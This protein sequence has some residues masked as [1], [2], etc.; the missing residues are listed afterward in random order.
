MAWPKICEGENVLITAPTGSGKTHT[1]FLWS[2]N[3]FATGD[4]E[5]GRTRVLYISPLKALNNDIQRNLLAPLAELEAAFTKQGESF[6]ELSIATRSGDTSSEE[7]RRMLRKPPDILI[8]TPESLN[9]LLSSRGGQ[10]LLHDVDTVILDEIHG[11][12]D[13]K[14][15][16]YLMSAV[17]RLVRFSGEFQRIALS[18]TINPLETVARFVAGF[19]REKTSYVPRDIKILQS[20]SNKHYDIAI[21]YPEKSLNRPEDEQIWESMAEDLLE[22]IQD[23]QSTLIFVNSRALCEKLTFKINSAARS[24]VAYAHHGSLSREIRTD[25]E[26]RLKA[27]ELAAIV[28]TSSLE[29]GIDIGALDEVILVQSPGSIASTIQRIGRAGH[30]VGATSRCTIYPT[31]PQDF[32][33]SAVLAKSVMARAIEPV[34]TIANPL[35]VLGQVIIS[36]TGTDTWDLDELF[37]E[38]RCSTPYNTLT[39][40]AFDLVINMLLGR[41]AE[42]H[43]HDLKPRIRLDRENNTAEAR[44]GALLSLYLSGGVIPD[45]GYFQLRV[46]GSNARLGELDEEFVWEARV[47]KVFSLGTQSWQVKK[48]THNDVLVAPAK[49]DGIAPPFWKSESISRS[50]EYSSKIGEFLEDAEQRVEDPAFESYLIEQHYTEPA[51]AK[52]IVEFLKQQREQTRRPLPHR[53]HLLFE[54]VKRGPAQ[55]SGSQLVIHSGWGAEVNRPFAMAIEAAWHKAFGE[56]P[57]VFVANESLVMQLTHPISA[58]D[59]FAMVEPENLEQLLRARLEGSG[60]FGARFRENAGRALLLSKGKFNE[61]KPLWMSRLQSQKLMDAVMKYEDFPILLETWR[62]CLQDEFDVENLKRALNEVRQR[63]IQISEIESSSPSPF[64]RSIAWEQIN[65]YMYMG[66]EPKSTKTSQ[67]RDDLLKQVVFSP[68]LRAPISSEVIEQFVL[69]RQRMLEGYEPA[70][71]QELLDWLSERTCIPIPEWHAL[72]EKLAFEPD[73]QGATELD[74]VVASRHEAEQVKRTLSNPENESESLETLIANWL[75]YYGPITAKEISALLGVPLSQVVRCLTSLADNQTLVSGQLVED[76]EQETFCDAANY[77]H[78]LRLQRRQRRVEVISKPIEALTPFMFDWQTRRLPGEPLDRLFDVIDRLRLLPANSA[79]WEQEILPARL[80]GYRTEHLDLLFQEGEVIWTGNEDKKVQFIHDADT[81]LMTAPDAPSD[82]I[83]SDYA[84]FDFMGLL[85]Q[86]GL[87]STELNERLWDEVWQG[88]ISNDTPATLRKGIL[89]DFK[90]SET[91]PTQRGGSRRASFKRWRGQLPWSGNWFRLR[92]QSDELEPL[93]ALELSKDKARILMD[94][95]GIVFRELCLRESDGFR[96]SEIFRALRLMELSGE[97]LPGHFFD[98]INGP[99][100]VTS[101]SL[102]SFQAMEDEASL[103]RV[104]FINAA[105]P[106]SPS[107]LGLRAHGDYLPRR[108][109]SNYLVYH[110]SELVATVARSGKTLQLLV[111]PDNQSIERYLVVLDHLAHRDFAPLRRLTIETINEVPAASSPYLPALEARFNC[112]PDQK[113]ITIQREL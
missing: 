97:V 74:N 108:I 6:P 55:A 112:Y 7:R 88:R 72:T 43:I 11:V 71:D 31:H 2:L 32:I 10:T 34:R 100:Y 59:L 79:L 14:R 54:Q 38:L 76:D 41:Y 107:G 96:W 106:V 78:L 69:R 23:N 101:S 36:M 89:N 53:H 103:D 64:A 26:S 19:Q 48:I 46:E 52:E 33:E 24:V 86:S 47:G 84:R 95:Y 13:S 57:E 83:D 87:T 44:K 61:R 93:E 99:Q 56:Q 9:L 62:T 37:N 50:F 8:T 67:L 63:D 4:L 17:E 80:P 66:D 58:A 3:R 27:G 21:R 15:G 91:T 77:E 90:V 60:F 94:R 109:A 111:P 85:D 28:A 18:A 110:G 51:A 73:T 40:Q 75:Q 65:T 105:D 35:D 5:T 49:P 12:V 22:R 68:E 29:M 113:Y 82:L 39:R 102:R 81:A 30:Q 25:V 70:D 42:H 20:Q 45:R 16:V 104:F 98:G 1:A 92:Y